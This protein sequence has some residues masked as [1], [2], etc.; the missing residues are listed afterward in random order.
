MYVQKSKVEI[1][2]QIIIHSLI[3]EKRIEHLLQTQ[4]NTIK[5]DG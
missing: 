5:L 4:K 1:L 3:N 2:Y